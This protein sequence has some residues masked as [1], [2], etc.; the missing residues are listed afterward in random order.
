[1]GDSCPPGCHLYAVFPVSDRTGIPLGL[2]ER[3]FPGATIDDAWLPIIELSNNKLKV[4]DYLSWRR[5]GR[6]E[7]DR[8][9]FGLGMEAT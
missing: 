1:M 8:H 9:E 4:A 6:T 2:L 5:K 7:I 3:I